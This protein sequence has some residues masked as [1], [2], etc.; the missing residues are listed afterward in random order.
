MKNKQGSQKR[1]V[2]I[3]VSTGTRTKRLR[4]TAASGGRWDGTAPSSLLMLHR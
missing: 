4:R 1:H 3:S 2:A